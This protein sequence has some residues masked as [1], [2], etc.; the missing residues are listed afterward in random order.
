M[1]KAAPEEDRDEWMTPPE[2]FT[3]YN[4]DFSFDLDAASS[5]HNTLCG[6]YFDKDADALTMEWK[7]VGVDIKNVWLNPPFSDPYQQQFLE[8]AFEQC[9]KHVI[10]VVCTIPIAP[11]T[12]RWTEVVVKASIIEMLY[13][14]V[15]YLHPLTKKKVSGVRW[16]TA[17]VI[18]TPGYS[19]RWPSVR[20]RNWK[21]GEYAK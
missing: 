6:Y 21:T 15:N 13:P 7:P 19:N 18:F 12:K 20:W 3:L 2:L 4:Q 1:N 8:K 16:P 17:A 10:N 9:N 5:E 11:E 14:R